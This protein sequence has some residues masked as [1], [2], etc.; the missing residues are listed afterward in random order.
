MIDCATFIGPYPFRELPHPDPDVLVRVLARE[1]LSG[2]WV[3]Y[4][5]SAWHRDPVPGNASLFREL[6]PHRDVLHP[7]PVVRPDWPD[8]EHTLRDV[9]EQGAACVRAYPMHW[10]MGPQDPNLRALALAC[11]V[12]GIPLLL[13]VR[14]EDLRQRHPLDAV[15]DLTAAHVRFLARAGNVRIIVTGAGRELLEE[16]HWGLTPDE[17]RR[18][19]WDFAWIWGPPED[20]LAHLFRTVGAERFVHGT[21]WPLRLTQTPRANLDLLPPDLRAHGISDAQSLGSIRKMPT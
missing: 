3:G 12:V 5:P 7:A 19:H 6:A 8:W 9:V 21:H 14:F 10:G 4:L 18:V 11:A 13:T 20:H 15:G 16:V 1:G 17:Q 2:A